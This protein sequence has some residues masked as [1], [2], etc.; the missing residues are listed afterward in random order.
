MIAK[1]P[2]VQDWAQFKSWMAER[3]DL[4]EE[5]FDIKDGE[6]GNERMLMKK[7]MKRVK[8]SLDRLNFSDWIDMN[9]LK[10]K[11]LFITRFTANLN[12]LHDRMYGN[13]NKKHMPNKIKQFKFPLDLEKKLLFLNNKRN[14]LSHQEIRTKEIPMFIKKYYSQF[15]E[16]YL[17]FIT[18]LAKRQLLLELGSLKL[19]SSEKFV[20]EA[21]DSIIT[22]FFKKF[23]GSDVMR[24]KSFYVVL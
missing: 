7:I 14:K 22:M 8:I 13:I 12:N 19:T 2:K 9:E 3:L 24:I 20:N 11:S 21:Y 16:G 17:H 23:S 6:S 5:L 18:C 15:K 4:I 10:D 1:I